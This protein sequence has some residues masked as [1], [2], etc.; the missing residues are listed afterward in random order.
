MI[1]KKKA[2]LLLLAKDA[3]ENTKKEFK[4]IC[5]KFDVNLIEFSDIESISK[6]IG[7]RNKAV[8]CIKNINFAKEILKK[9]DGGETIG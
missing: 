9:I 3:S 6:A 2:K 5:D 4:F 8:I 1:K 7:K